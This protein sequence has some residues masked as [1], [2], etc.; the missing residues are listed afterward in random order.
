MCSHFPENP[1]LRQLSQI[2]EEYPTGSRPILMF[3]IAV[4]DNGTREEQKNLS[5]IASFEFVDQNEQPF[6]YTSKL[7][8]FIETSFQHYSYALPK[9]EEDAEGDY[10]LTLGCQFA[11][12]R[13][14]TQI[15]TPT[16]THIHTY[17]YT[18]THVIMFYCLIENSGGART[19]VIVS[20]TV[21]RTEG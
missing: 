6:N 17:T 18:Y 3:V 19:N 11:L 2:E 13:V 5:S 10:I 1:Y 4:D 8:E 15:H 14:H 7:T 16:C 20:I 21:D 9:L 12:V